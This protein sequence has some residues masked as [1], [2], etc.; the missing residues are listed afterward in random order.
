MTTPPG[1]NNGVGIIIAGDAATKIP[2]RDKAKF[3]D[4]RFAG[5][6]SLRGRVRAL[7]CNKNRALDLLSTSPFL[8][9]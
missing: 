7:G 6:G 5:R 8:T 9:F 2:L 3:L 1:A 4:P